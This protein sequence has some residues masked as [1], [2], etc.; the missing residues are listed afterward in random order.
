MST[1]RAEL[2]LALENLGRGPAAVARSVEEVALALGIAHLLDRSTHELS[3]G[4]L[5]RVVLGAA[6]APRPRLR[7]ARRADLPAGPGGRR[8][9]HLAAAPPQRGVGDGRR[10][11]RASPRA[12]PGR[13]RPGD[14][15]GP[16]GAWPATATRAGSCSGPARTRRPAD[17][18]GADVRRRRAAAAADRRQAG[19]RD[20]C[21]PPDAAR[22]AR[23]GR[24]RGPERRAAR[25]VAALAR[26][27]TAADPPALRLR[28]VWHELRD[29]PAILRGVDLELSG[30]RD[31]RADGPQ[32]RR[33]VD[34][35]AP[36]RRAADP[37][38]RARG[39]GR[40]GR[41]ADAEPGRLLPARDAWARR[42]APTRSLAR[43]FRRCASATRAT[44]PAASASG[45]PSPSCSTARSGR[46]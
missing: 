35:A 37:H 15:D 26:G 20:A 17:P 34:A 19:S 16:T 22:R 18:G 24:A 41:A 25:A 45:S 29:G 32:R 38:P 4:E 7:A 36:R 21:A 46:R 23:R 9:A 1:V 39:T 43:D 42:R 6:L 40:A 28:G 8:R 30:G 11:R 12:L 13:R 27:A 3:G 44:C 14:R 31:G 10:A 2:S 33:Q 5:Q